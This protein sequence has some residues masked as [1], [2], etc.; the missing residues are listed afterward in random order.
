M[1]AAILGVIGCAVL[2]EVARYPMHESP[3]SLIPDERLRSVVRDSLTKADGQPVTAA[4]LT[5]L[6]HLAAQRDSIAHLSGLEHAINLVS[7]NL[8]DNDTCDLSPRSGLAKFKKAAPRWQR[9]Q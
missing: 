7:L 1:L 8:D 9:H 3:P 6:T 2:R 5:G 4:D